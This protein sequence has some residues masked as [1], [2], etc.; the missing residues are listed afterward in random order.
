M[1]LKIKNASGTVVKV[2]SLKEVNDRITARIQS[3]TEFKTINSSPIYGTGNFSL[4]PAITAG[5]STQYWTGAKTW[6]SP[7]TAPVSASTNLITS[8]AVYD[9]IEDVIAGGI[10]YDTTIASGGQLSVKSGL[11]YSDIKV[12][13]T[14]HIADTSIHV[15]TADKTNWNGKQAAITATGILKGDGTGGITTAVADT[16]YQSV[17]ST[18]TALTNG[19]YKITTNSYGQV[20]LGTAVVKSDITS[21]GIPGSDTQYSNATTLAD[22]LMSKEDKAKLDGIEDDSQENVI[23]S[24]SINGVAQTIT[25]KNVDLPAYPVINNNTITINSSNTS[26]L[27]PG[28]DTFTLNGTATTIDLHEI[29]KTGDYGDLLNTPDLTLKADKVTSATSGNFAGLNSS[30]NLTDSGYDASDFDAAGSAATVQTNLTAHT[31]NT[32]NPHQ[33]TLSQAA[34][35]QGTALTVVPAAGIYE[36][37]DTSTTGATTKYQTKTEVEAIALS[38][39]Q[40]T[41]KYMGQ[42]KYGSEDTTDMAAINSYNL[43]VGDKCGVHDTQLTYEYTAGTPSASDDVASVNSGYYWKAE[44]NGTDE[45]GQYY[46][47]VFWFGTWQNGITYYGEVSAT[48]TCSDAVTPIWDLIVYTNAIPDGSITDAKIGTRA[49]SDTTSAPANN[50]TAKS[51]TSW[52]QQFYSNIKYLDGYKADKVTSATAGNFAGLDTNGNLT[53]SNYTASSFILSSNLNA[54]TLSTT[55]TTTV[56]SEKTV[57][58]AISAVNTSITSSIGD[59]KLTITLAPA[60]GSTVTNTEFTA[61]QAANASTTISVPAAYTIGADG[62]GSSASIEA[63]WTT[64]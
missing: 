45:V 37:T 28:S 39:Q 34:T 44:A 49:V 32:S 61:N 21:L 17:L 16:D 43:T 53:D 64:V 20:S 4:E 50:Y 40:G 51:L 8:G 58:D 22:G 52:L 55:S 26:S 18:Y 6:Q 41:A 2:P 31:S 7:D 10:T 36:G 62:G 5:T 56:P 30:G 27:T 29:S 33:T 9:A 63:D 19:L 3:S 46:D 42:L 35:A 14:T 59:G 15:T 12:P 47:E 60:D 38:Y 57:A 11:I 25:S 23:E 24:I 48:I 1:A 54:S 13:L